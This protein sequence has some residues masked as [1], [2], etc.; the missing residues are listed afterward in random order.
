MTMEVKSVRI[1]LFESLKILFGDRTIRRFRLQKATYLLGY[2]SLSPN[3]LFQRS[4]LID[5]FWPESIGQSGRDSLNS[6]L[7]CI[8]RELEP[9][10]IIRSD[11]REVGLDNELCTLD[12]VKFEAVFKNYRRADAFQLKEQL[13]EEATELYH[14]ELLEGWY[15]DWISPF[16][17]YYHELYYDLL[18]DWAKVTCEKADWETSTRVA[19]KAMHMA[20]LRE[21]A[22]HIL[23][24]TL[25]CSGQI[26]RAI[27]VFRA[28][29]K[30]VRAELDIEPSKE[31]RSLNDQL[32][33]CTYQ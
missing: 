14:G 12:I 32:R 11:R 15:E 17:G 16:R 18:T 6:A 23:M 21:E 27:E 30:R 1:Q 3:K 13:Y 29:Q 10:E 22:T 33:V 28:Y 8:R 7:T 26:A 5:L 31:L 20:P 9:Y 24:R 4:D 2:L 19:T 25:A